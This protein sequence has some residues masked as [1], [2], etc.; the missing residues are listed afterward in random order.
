MKYPEPKKQMLHEAIHH[1]AAASLKIVLLFFIAL[2]ALL[3]LGLLLKIQPKE[4]TKI[5]MQQQQE[6]K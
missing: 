2:F 6:L 1:K 4:G 5:T 3:Q